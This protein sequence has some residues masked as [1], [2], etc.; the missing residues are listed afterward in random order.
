MTLLKIQPQGHQAG[1]AG[2][3]VGSW[4]DA[5]EEL[6]VVLSVFSQLIQQARVRLQL[7]AKCKFLEVGDFVYKS[8]GEE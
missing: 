4:V 5:G 7:V 3:C 2:V 8:T 6:D 1:K